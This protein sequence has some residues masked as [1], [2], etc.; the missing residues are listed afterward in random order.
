MKGMCQDGGSWP[1]ATFDWQEKAMFKVS[2][3]ISERK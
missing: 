1:N 3:N 2:S